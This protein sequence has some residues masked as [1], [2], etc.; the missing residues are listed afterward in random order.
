MK[1]PQ[2]DELIAEMERLQQVVL[3]TRRILGPLNRH[4]CYYRKVLE[5]LESEYFFE[6]SM[7]MAWIGMTLKPRRILEI[8]TRN[9]GSLLDLLSMFFRH[10]G[11]RVVCC[12]LWREIGSPAAVRRNLRRMNVPADIVEFVSGDS[13]QVVPQ[14]KRRNPGALF[15]YILVDGCH[16]A[17]VARQ[18]LENVW[19]MLDV[20]GALV[21]DDIGPESY[22][23]IDVWRDFQSAHRSQFVWYEK[24][25][26]KGVAWAFRL[27]ES[28][29]DVESMPDA[30]R[31]A[32]FSHP[33]RGFLDRRR[34][35]LAAMPFVAGQRARRLARGLL[36]GPS[37]LRS[38]FG[39]STA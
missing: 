34:D 38:R 15:D 36:K 39:K 1:W 37:L 8:G 26:R 24:Q 7:V 12:D 18:D 35:D 10:D 31:H 6:P 9:G 11:M 19:D 20:G 4:D 23:L 30:G 17:D 22:C 5:Y 32:A 14:W 25:W 28:A 21:F 16:D 29:S 13:L 3:N 33:R 27:D 2:Q